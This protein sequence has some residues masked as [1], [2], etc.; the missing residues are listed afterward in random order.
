MALIGDMSKQ[1]DFNDLTYVYKGESAAINFIGTKGPLHIFKSICN[2][3]IALE[4]VRKDK[5]NLN[6][7]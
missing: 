5:K 3:N 7:I 6:H 4:D 2:G 1:I